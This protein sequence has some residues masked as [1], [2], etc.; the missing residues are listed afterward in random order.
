MTVRTITEPSVEPVT[1]AEAKEWL[2][3]ESGDTTAA[4]DALLALLVKAM[5]A[6]AENLTGRAFVQRTLELTLPEFPCGEIELPFPPL[7]SVT[8][9]KYT[10]IGGELQTVDAVDYEV[11]A[12]GE[13]GRVQPAWLS[14]WP[15][16]RGVFNAVQVR[17][18]AGYAP[19]GSPTD[20]AE[21]VPAAVKLW[22]HARLATLW[23]DRE[24]LIG[25]NRQAIPRAF[26]DG[27]LDALVLGSRVA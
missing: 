17:Y 4:Q 14:S 3:I 1:V 8:H 6:Y 26:A 21:N 16:T 5:R 11:D 20:D 9:V 18:V 15:A 27:L 13:P 22:M 10:D 7:V 25:A 12:Y 23:R 19:T 24:Q 2:R